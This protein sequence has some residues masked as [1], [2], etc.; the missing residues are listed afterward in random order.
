MITCDMQFPIPEYCFPNITLKLRRKKK[1]KNKSVQKDRE[2]QNT[3]NKHYK[4]KH[5]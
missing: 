4:T 3:R 2:T 5:N 1:K